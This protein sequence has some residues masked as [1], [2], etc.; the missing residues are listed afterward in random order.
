MFSGVR[1]GP[2]A[3]TGVLKS[4]AELRLGQQWGSSAVHQCDSWRSSGRNNRIALP[5]VTGM[6][7]LEEDDIRAVL[8]FVVT[9]YTFY[10]SAFEAGLKN[11]SASVILS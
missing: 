3:T 9:R 6:V 10:F 5:S 7:V 8:F 2:S 11:F 4:D 1:N